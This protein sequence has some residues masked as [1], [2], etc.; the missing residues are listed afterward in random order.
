MEKTFNKFVSQQIDYALHLKRACSQGIQAIGYELVTDCL[1]AMK[2]KEG[3]GYKAV[4]YE[5]NGHLMEFLFVNCVLS[6]KKYKCPSCS[7]NNKFSLPN[8]TFQSF[9]DFYCSNCNHQFEIKSTKSAIHK[10]GAYSSLQQFIV[11][12]GDPTN[13]V[14]NKLQWLKKGTRYKKRK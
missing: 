12:V 5:L 1:N 7:Y 2:G 10:K 9:C 11:H 3:N 6:W 13:V 4:P 14:L 8:V